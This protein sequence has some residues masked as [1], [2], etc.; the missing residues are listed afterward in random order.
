[1]GQLRQLCEAAIPGKEACLPKLGTDLGPRT[2]DAHKI[3]FPAVA[4]VSTSRRTTWLEA[5]DAGQKI[6]EARTTER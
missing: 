6:L 2:M 1:M 3:I 4:K 5:I